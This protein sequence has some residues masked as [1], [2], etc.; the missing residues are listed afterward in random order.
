[1][2]LR[3]SRSAAAVAVIND[4]V[5]VEIKGFGTRFHDEFI[6]H[7]N[8]A[9]LDFARAKA[10]RIPMISS[11]RHDRLHINELVER[12]WLLLL[13]LLVIVVR[14]AVRIL[15]SSGARHSRLFVRYRRVLFILRMWRVLVERLGHLLIL[16]CFPRVLNHLLD[17]L[18]ALIGHLGS[19]ESFISLEEVALKIMRLG[20]HTLL[21]MLL[22]VLNVR[23]VQANVVKVFGIVSKILV[24]L[25][26]LLDEHIFK[27]FRIIRVLSCIL[28]TEK[29]FLRLI[30]CHNVKVNLVT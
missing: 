6:V 11:L 7:I 30:A 18:L 20:T 2:P 19:H 15:L 3:L 14:T 22:L 27:N 23:R 26:S 8:Y 16:N 12:L 13:L 25:E 21:L 17:I 24:M 4:D 1:M 28:L 10:M 9:Y 29:R 5:V